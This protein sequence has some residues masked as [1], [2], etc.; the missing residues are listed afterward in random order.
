MLHP[1]QPQP[2]RSAGGLLPSVRVALAPYTDPQYETRMK[3][4]PGRRALDKVYK[5]RDRYEIP[6]WQR[7]KVWDVAKKQQLIDSILRGW[8][9]PKFYFVK[10]AEDEYEV[11]DGQQRLTAIYEFF[12]NELP[13]QEDSRKLFGGPLYKDLKPSYSDAFDDFEIDYDEIEN[14]SEEELKQFFQRLQQGLPLRS[15]EKLN[16]VH[17]KLRDFC[18]QQAKHKFVAERIAVPDTRF[19]HFDIITKAGAIEIEGIDTGLRFDDLKKIFE[20]QGTFSATS[21]VAK[22]IQEALEFLAKA[23]PRLEPA[24]KNRTIVQSVITFGCKLVETGSA[25]G[26][27]KNVASF[28]KHFLTELAHQVELG[29]A[30]TDYDYIRF[31]KSV[32]ANVKAG[33]RIRQEVL[34]RKAFMHDPALADAF[35]ALVIATSGIGARVA[36]LGEA[37]GTQIGNLNTAYAAKHGEDLFKAT[38]KTAQALLN[39]GK[40][41]RDLASYKTLIDDLYFLFRE[42]LGQRLKDRLPPSFVDVNTLRTDLQHDVDHGD[43]RKVAAKRK[44]IGTTFRGYAGAASPEVLEPSRFVLLQ[45]NVLSALILDLENLAV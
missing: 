19:S 30:A 32:N 20:A 2:T 17:S 36:E 35:D 40:P 44:K 14:A 5:R 15:S 11:V 38:N 12:A 9:L 26:L 28:I 23:F 24:L 43:K 45:A 42:S 1:P 29:Q 31:Q 3:I 25:K 41:I 6:E 10:A 37:I 39:I 16:A 22:R 33:P 34:L 27:E 13:L 4:T 18:R 21:A 8:R 7:G